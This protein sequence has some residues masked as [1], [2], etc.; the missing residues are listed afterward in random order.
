[1]HLI[2]QLAINWSRQS[3]LVFL[4]CCDRT[5]RVTAL[6]VEFYIYKKKKT[7]IYI[8]RL[9]PIK[10][11]NHHWKVA[12]MLFSMEV[13]LYVIRNKKEWKRTINIYL[14]I[15]GMGKYLRDYFKFVK[16]L[17]EYILISLDWFFFVFYFPFIK[18]KRMKL[19]QII[20]RMN[21][22]SSN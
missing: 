14:R 12:L 10:I 4:L 2:Q 7:N 1:M 13:T 16:Y 15:D 11:A 17:W 22:R 19:K 21:E 8:Q 9:L 20:K 5:Q 3:L 6:Q 18:W